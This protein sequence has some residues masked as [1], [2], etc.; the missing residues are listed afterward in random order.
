MRKL[1]KSMF[2]FSWSMTL[3][4]AKTL[5]RLTSRT[6]ED[7]AASGLDAVTEAAEDQL[8]GPLKSLYETA[9]RVQS[10]IVDSVF[11]DTASS[12]GHQPHRKFDKS[13][14]VVLGDGLA[15]GMGHFSLTGSA[16]ATS[17][18]ALL[19]QV[20]DTPFEQPL[21]QAPGLGDV[22]GLKP[23]KPIVPQ[24]QQTTVRD[25]LPSQADLGNL[26][27]P[28]FTV[29]DAISRRPRVPLVDRE[30]SLGTL[31][32]FILGLPD[33]MTSPQGPTQ[34]E[35]ACR[36]NPTLVLVSLGYD[37][38][39]QA[40]VAGDPGHLPCAR[41][42]G[43]DFTRVLR[44]LSPD[45]LILATTVPD[46]LDSAYFS[47]LETAAKILKTTPQFLRQHYQLADDALVHLHGLYEIG[48]Q[49][50]ARQVGA[51]AA[52]PAIDGATAT[53]IRA[54]VGNVN[55]AILAAA[56]QHGAQVYDLHGLIANLARNG[57]PVGGKQ[58]SCD[59]LGGLFLLNG[60]YP[61]AALN[62]LIADDMVRVINAA[63]D[64][65][66]SGVGVEGIAAADA[67]TQAELAPGPPATDQFLKP[68]TLDD[69][70]PF[71]PLGPN[72]HPYPIQTTYPQLQPGKEGCTPL[73]GMPAEGIED[74]SYDGLNLEEKPITPLKLPEGLEQTLEINAELSFF[75]DALRPVDC[76]DDQPIIPG[77]PPFGVCENTF[78]GGLMPTTSQLSGKVNI[79]FSPPDENNNTT[80]EI[81]HP[82]DLIGADGD[83][84]APQLF[85]MPSH[86]TR[87]VDIPEFVSTG[88]L[89][90]TTGQVTNFHYN[91]RNFPN[92]ALQTLLNL[93]PEVGIRHAGLF[94]P[95]P[96]NGGESWARFEQRPD[97]QLDV[98]LGG[99]MIV[100]MG[101]AAG[102]RPLRFPLPF[103]TPDL[104]PASFVARGTQ[105]HPRI[106]VTS[107]AS[108]KPVASAEVPNIPFNTV[109]EFTSF[110]RNTCFG[111]AFGLH[112]PELGEG[113][114]TG[115]SQLLSRAL[116]QFGPKTGDTVP[117]VLRILPPGGLLNET[118]VP[119]SFLP[120][121]SSRAASGFDA[122]MRFPKQTYPQAGLA[123]PDDPYIFAATSIHL[124]TGKMVSPLLW[125]GFV[126]Q[127]LFAALVE[128]EPCTPAAA[129]NYMGP[130][131]FSR[132][133]NDQL[134]LHWNGSVYIPYPK[135]FN[136]PSPNPG[137]RPPIVIQADSRLDP[138]R[139]VQAMQRIAPTCGGTM[140][141]HEHN[142]VSSTDQTFSYSYSIPHE[143]ARAG[144][145]Q[146]EY[147]NQTKGGTFRLTTLAWVDFSHSLGSSGRPDTVTFTGFGTWSEDS[148]GALH[149]V[150]AQI[151]AAPHAPYVGIQIDG[152]LTS[153]VDTK[154]Q[155]AQL[156]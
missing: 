45:P 109:Q 100:P 26:S 54:A 28:G 41:A 86:F 124:K 56:N 89:N 55:A 95:G 133:P 59:Y 77:F 49:L 117:V 97:G 52:P 53:A 25:P 87:V 64:Q 150:S 148:S 29:A 90:L 8:D 58:L 4:G 22:I 79:K 19:A 70:P 143:T 9:D 83:L 80:F 153:N 116:I 103:A 75:G 60:A 35:Y 16:Q 44:G 92:T 130:A 88:V 81:R 61:G 110:T 63:H 132:D 14:F 102:D 31:T 46:P 37:Q 154:P 112:A 120:P 141:G 140:S 57:L 105:L 36:R 126:V 50:M 101:L 131:R 78:F 68:R 134:V 73:V 119:P 152:G 149:F 74:P 11:G 151:S 98:S 18:P 139:R 106:F 114:A 128:V 13:T 94:F 82:G 123:S 135:G 42:F 84:I 38:L 43:T 104:Q 65:T 6:P 5:A 2:N 96:P 23:Q 24:L 32:N 12:P 47:D 156:A 122:I 85:R 142:V 66:F 76:P 138:F 147:G 145:A 118:P 51:L 107:K 71:A 115:R 33:L 21:I 93:N 91:V 39:L 27:V 144:D 121:G 69:L 108:P 155:Q 129:F 99:H 127:E 111:D 20:L 72:Q 40:A 125:R 17:F 113:G 15:A 34:V 67:N 10:Q 137:G 136:F 7:S 3:L 48:Y 146:F 30:S 62:A 1:V